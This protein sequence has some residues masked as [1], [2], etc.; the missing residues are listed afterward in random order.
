MRACSL[1]CGLVYSR[2]YAAEYLNAAYS[3]WFECM[4]IVAG[5]F[6]F[7][8]MGCLMTAWCAFVALDARANANTPRV[9]DDGWE[10]ASPEA[11]G[12]LPSPL[13]R[14]AQVIRSQHASIDSVLVVRH[15]KLVFEKYFNA[16]RIKKPH[17]LA[18]AGKSIISA[19]IGIAM[20]QGKI[21]SEEQSIYSLLPYRQYANW[22]AEKKTVRLKH[23]L[24]MTPGWDCVG[25]KPWD[26]KRCGTVR[27]EGHDPHKWILD[28]PMAAKPGE[29]FN[30]TDAASALSTMLL[31]LNTRS[32]YEDFY[33]ENLLQPLGLRRPTATNSLTSREMAK[34][35]VLYLHNGFWQGKQIIPQIWVEKSTGVQFD[36]KGESAFAKAY[37]YFWWLRDFHVDEVIYP[38]YMAAGNGGQLIL[39]LSSL[40]MV[41]VMTG[42]YYHEDEKFDK[43]LELIERFVI[44]AVIKQ[45][46]AEPAPG[47]DAQ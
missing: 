11:V 2:Q 13:Q 25:D 15:D 43:A 12:M 41:V 14:M 9:I 23:V 30:Y 24:S 20:G 18:S 6:V 36:F 45:T 22:S 47:V 16:A 39:I 44:P 17:P 40:D 27:R 10:V 3:L 21:K 4:R 19:L 46:L 38:A 33:Y 8:L 29:V 37:G 7:R 34:F 35:G 28:L 1:S 31:V 42:H 5:A 32:R 26:A